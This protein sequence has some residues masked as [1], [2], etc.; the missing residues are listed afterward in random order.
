MRH[1]SPVF[2]LV[3]FLG[4]SAAA[5]QANFEERISL[6][7]TGDDDLATQLRTSLRAIPNV[8]VNDS[9]PNHVVKVITLTTKVNGNAVGLVSAVVITSAPTNVRSF[10]NLVQ[11]LAKCEC[12]GSDIQTGLVG[13]SVADRVEFKAFTLFTGPLDSSGMARRIAA[14]VTEEAIEPARQAH[15]SLSKPRAPQ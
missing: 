2:G 4:S 14:F 12:K 9:S 8:T 15:E 10:W 11:G 5:Q 1:L 7:A 6:V 13:L 3:V